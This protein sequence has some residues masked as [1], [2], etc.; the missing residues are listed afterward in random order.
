DVTFH[1]TYQNAVDDVLPQSSPL[2][3]VLGQVIYVRVDY[4]GVDTDCPTIVELQLIV[5]PTPEIADP[6]PLELCDDAVADGM[7]QFDL[8]Q[9]NTEI[10]NGL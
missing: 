6:S 2:S 1:L 9:A 4:A 8:T 7:T 5:Q 3:N 10:L